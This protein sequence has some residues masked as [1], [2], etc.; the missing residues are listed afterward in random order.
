M[1]LVDIGKRLQI[2][3]RTLESWKAAEKWGAKG[4]EQAKVEVLTRQLFMEQM[5]REGL[6]AT[7]AMKLLIEGM[8]KP[9]DLV[10]RMETFVNEDGDLETREVWEEV[11]DYPTRHKYQA[12]YWKLSGLSQPSQKGLEVNAGEGG[13]VNIAV[14][15]P[16]KDALSG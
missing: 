3:V 6:T 9:A 12:E 13:V 14:N 7:D 4:S 1:S 8:T 2:P 5:A 11:P 15:L 16:A 10:K